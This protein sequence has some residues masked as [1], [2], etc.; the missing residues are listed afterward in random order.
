MDGRGPNILFFRLVGMPVPMADN[1]QANGLNNE[2]ETSLNF[3]TQSIS[4]N[5]PV[6]K[7]S[8]RSQSN[9]EKTDSGFGVSIVAA[10][11]ES[12]SDAAAPHPLQHERTRQK[13]F[14]KNFKHLQEEVVSQRK[15]VT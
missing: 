3:T 6:S 14:V 11:D 2:T 5:R 12:D 4:T 9:T 10:E 13:K 15:F 8:T 1:L 7:T